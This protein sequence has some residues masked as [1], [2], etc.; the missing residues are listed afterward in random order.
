MPM[1]I[2]RKGRLCLSAAS[3]CAAELPLPSGQDLGAQQG[4]ASAPLFAGALALAGAP[5]APGGRDCGRF[6]FFFEG[7]TTRLVC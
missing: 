3:A 2:A 7:G 6:F 1:A 5:A 4:V